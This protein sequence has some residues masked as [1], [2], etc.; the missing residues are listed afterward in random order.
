[1]GERETDEIQRWIMTN[2]EKPICFFL[3]MFVLKVYRKKSFS[4]SPFDW[5]V[6]FIYT[7]VLKTHSKQAAKMSKKNSYNDVW[8][9]SL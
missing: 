8:S 1:M 2:E 9:K 7:A 3:L 5:K 6:L 4:S